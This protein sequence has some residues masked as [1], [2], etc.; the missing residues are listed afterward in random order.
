MN[1]NQGNLEITT[2]C[3]ERVFNS[4]PAQGGSNDLVVKILH[5]HK[6]DH[7]ITQSKIRLTVTDNTR[8]QDCLLSSKYSQSINRNE[9]AAGDIIRIGEMVSGTYSLKKVIYI[10]EILEMQKGSRREAPMSSIG[11]SPSKRKLDEMTTRETTKR[12]GDKKIGSIK[13]LN[14]FQQK[15]WSIKAKVV[16]KTT[17]REYMKDGRAGK[18]FSIIVTDGESKCNI[19]FFTEFVDGFFDKIQIYKTY[20]ITGGALKLANKKYVEDIHDYEIFVD[21]SFTITPTENMLNA[22]KMPSV[23]TRISRLREKMSEVVSLL[24][25]IMTVGEIETVIRKKDQA[26]MKKRTLKV[27]DD[28]GEAVPF[29][30]WEETA[31]MDFSVGDVLLL[32]NVRVSEYQNMPQIGMAR[33]GIISFNPELP[34]VFKLKGW[35]NKN[36]G[37]FSVAEPRKSV[38]RERQKTKLEEVKANGME[39][40][41]VKCTILY[42]SEKSVMYP[43]CPMDN[44]N[45]KVEHPAESPENYYCSK[46]DRIYTNCSQS[47]SV[48][49]SIA[50]DTSS[51]WLS[52]F[53][54]SASVLFNNLKAVEMEDLST[55]DHDEYKKTI[56]K[57]IG[58]EMVI[59]IRG[60]ETR[61]NGEPSIQYTAVSITPVDY[62][63]ESNNLLA[64]IRA[65]G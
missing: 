4:T 8:E 1:I 26:T 13:E 43:S 65:M 20:E 49:A 29:V 60:R 34:E 53:G 55:E 39:Y 48:S 51:V 62:L 44:C 16:S 18:V 11:A 38:G 21:R 42:I 59:R 17:V 33:D 57:S 9:I 37:T 22:V 64:Q 7:S 27:G 6:P 36:E 56:A 3:I 41:T 19:I 61:Y 25:V 28:S 24:V 58:E 54:D 14:P 23:V 46:C 15:A 45:K 10:K 52:L 30:L 32:E 47:Y 63:E 12:D 40:A 5:I 31:D 50:D 2:G 35:Y